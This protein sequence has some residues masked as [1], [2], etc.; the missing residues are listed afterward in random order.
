MKFVSFIYETDILIS[1]GPFSFRLIY[2][3]LDP[4]RVGC[5]HMS[6]VQLYELGSALHMT[7]PD[8]YGCVRIKSGPAAEYNS[9]RVQLFMN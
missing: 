9:S 3:K 1:F 8:A 7:E 5:S 2:E 4:T 6:Q